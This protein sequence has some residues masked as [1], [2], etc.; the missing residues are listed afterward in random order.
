MLS[1]ENWYLSLH[2]SCARGRN[3]VVCK[4][5]VPAHGTNQN[6]KKMATLRDLCSN[7]P[8]Q[9]DAAA[10]HYEVV[11]RKNISFLKRMGALA[12]E[13]KVFSHCQ[14]RRPNKGKVKNRAS[15]EE[16]GTIG[17]MTCRIRTGNYTG[18]VCKSKRKFD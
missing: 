4:R 2:E 1:H 13:E 9:I 3:C 6:E 7:V 11:R 17:T 16:M 18:V 15:S 5:V 10:I 12:S 8:T 14:Q